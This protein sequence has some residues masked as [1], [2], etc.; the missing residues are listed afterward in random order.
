MYPPTS[1]LKYPPAILLKIKRPTL[2]LP[3][4]LGHC[5]A[6]QPLAVSKIQ[7]PHPFLSNIDES[8]FNPD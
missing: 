3:L 8:C 4:T 6:L 5:T 2:L 7:G 1:E